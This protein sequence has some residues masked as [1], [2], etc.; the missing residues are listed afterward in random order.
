MDPLTQ[1]L[2][3]KTEATSLVCK[4]RRVGEVTVSKVRSSNVAGKSPNEMEVFAGS[5]GAGEIVEL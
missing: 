1:S 2:K 4:P 3:S 5:L